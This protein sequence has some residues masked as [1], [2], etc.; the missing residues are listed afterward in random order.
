[1]AAPWWFRLGNSAKTQRS[2]EP[3]SVVIFYL[4]KSSSTRK[5]FNERDFV[6]YSCSYNKI[7]VHKVR[8]NN[9]KSV[10]TGC[11]SSDVYNAITGGKYNLEYLELIN[12]S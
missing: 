7:I 9:A 4:E 1:M 11:D 12:S 6:A 2:S 5:P 10:D 8:L 3:V